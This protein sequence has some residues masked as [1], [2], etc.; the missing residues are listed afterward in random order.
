MGHILLRER[1]SD[2]GGNEHSSAAR[3]GLVDFEAH[4]RIFK[5]KKM[6]IYSMGYILC[7]AVS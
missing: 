6:A 1:F 2:E 5:D 4:Q 7:G 3:Q